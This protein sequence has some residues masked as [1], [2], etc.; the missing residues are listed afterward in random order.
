MKFDS[1]LKTL[2][3]GLSKMPDSTVLRWFSDNSQRDVHFDLTRM[4]SEEPIGAEEEQQI[5]SG[6]FVKIRSRRDGVPLVEIWVE[7]LTDCVS[8]NESQKFFAEVP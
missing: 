4:W 1:C 2:P 7:K 8:P 5:L 3:V 6:K